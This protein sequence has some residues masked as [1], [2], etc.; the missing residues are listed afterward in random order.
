VPTVTE[1]LTQIE[2]AENTLRNLRVEASDRSEMLNPNTGK[3]ELQSENTLTAYY[4]GMP[5]SKCRAD[6]SHAMSRWVNGPVPYVNEKT[7]YAYNGKVG[8]QLFIGHDDPTGKLEPR[9]GM[10]LASRPPMMVGMVGYASGWQF[11][12]YGCFDE[13]GIRLSQAL[14]TKTLFPAPLSVREVSIASTKAV[15]L[16]CGTSGRFS[17]RWLFDPSH[18]WAMIGYYEESAQ[19]KV[20]QRISVSN[21]MDAG[22]GVFY[23]RDASLEIMDTD[24][25]PVR[26]TTFQATAVTANDPKFDEDIFTIHWPRGT[27]VQD[28][29][30]NVTFVAG[31]T[32]KELDERISQQVAQAMHDSQAVD[33]ANAPSVRGGRWWYWIAGIAIAAVFVTILVAR[34]RLGGRHAIM[35]F[36]LCACASTS[37]ALEPVLLR[38]CP[39]MKISNCGLNACLFVLRYYNRPVT[40]QSLSKALEVGE[41]RERA[42]SLSEIKDALTREGLVVAAF[43]Q[44]S[45]DEILQSAR[46]G[47]IVLFHTDNKRS[48]GHYLLAMSAT[49]ERVLIV[50]AAEGLA[51]LTP[52]ELRARHGAV[53]TG[54]FL[55]I[56]GPPN[57]WAVIGARDG[58][59]YRTKMAAGAGD[60]RVR[61]PFV[62]ATST[63]I[64]VTS[65]Q[66]D[67]GCLK[68]GDP[69]PFVLEPH[70]SGALELVF[71]RGRFGTG[72][73]QRRVGLVADGGSLVTALHL[74]VET[75]TVPADERL[76]WFPSQIDLGV[77]GVDEANSARHEVCFWVPPTVRLLEV[78]ASSDAL[79]LHR[80]SP[81]PSTQPSE[82]PT[83]VVYEIGMRLSRGRFAEH[84]KVRS[85]DRLNP[86][87]VIPIVA[88]VR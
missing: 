51:W 48:V 79:L 38:G 30:A 86:E 41:H 11:S 42:L 88:D 22:G 69:L 57:G 1:V 17:R 85:N 32:D 49:S 2:A 18:G 10:L 24:E 82:G 16:A 71:D 43:S 37:R 65:V 80:L 66:G 81:P 8:M 27:T 74:T 15:E 34:R 78:T 20:R 59:R 19:G 3:W 87:L 28:S 77:L 7:S 46:G 64:V 54:M 4:T 31:E 56:H 55:R 6:F 45:V 12:L 60:V 9:R 67:C 26:R 44:A 33:G 70:A 36:A 35:L 84:V 83:R 40:A 68:S 29:V 14:R 63:R 50:D 52:M 5:G 25:K 47:D 72:I 61:V 75:E 13:A 62:N 39:D 53:F 76:T 73:V 21:L 23:P 58:C